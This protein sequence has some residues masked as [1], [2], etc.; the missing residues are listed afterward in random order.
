MVKDLENSA[1]FDGQRLRDPGSAG[2]LPLHE[3]VS[4]RG[5]RGV[6]LSRCSCGEVLSFRLTEFAGAGFVIVNG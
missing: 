6:P 2:P 1:R 5:E 4:W 3:L